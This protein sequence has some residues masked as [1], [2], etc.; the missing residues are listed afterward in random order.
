MKGLRD[1]PLLLVVLVA[2]TA[3]L[4]VGWAG[5]LHPVENGASTVVVPVQYTVQQFVQWVINLG[6]IPHDLATLRAENARLQSQ[7]D[8]LT[9]QLVQLREI[10]IEN[11]NLREFLHLKEQSPE[12]F[13]P[14][15]DLLAA[16]VIGRDPSNLLRYLTIDRGSQDR[17][18]PGMPVITA[19]GLVGQISEVYNNSS[20]V[21][22]LTDP[23]SDVAALVQRSRATGVVEGRTG[24]YLVM[25][26]L[27]QT[28]GAAQVGDVILTSGLGGHFPRRLLIG[29]VT[30]VQR[31]DVDMFQE[32]QVRPAVDLDGLETVIVVRYFTPIAVDNPSDQAPAATGGR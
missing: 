19:R 6:R 29:E 22:L 7:V 31:R 26:F 10:Q 23:S 17:L 3:I 9:N 18:Q 11:A 13:G 2:S 28:S 16:E 21:K 30:A 25:R 32:A 12:I 8:E 24:P 1:W 5:A 14:E 20:K 27:P 4:I 15:S